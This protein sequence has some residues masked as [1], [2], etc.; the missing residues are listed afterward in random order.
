MCNTTPHSLISCITG[1]KHVNCFEV[2][3]A[4]MKYISKKNDIISSR[5][6][7]HYMIW[8][9]KKEKKI[10]L[11]GKG[12]LSTCLSLPLS[13]YPCENFVLVCPRIYQDGDL[14]TVNVST[15]SKVP[16]FKLTWFLAIN[17]ISLN[18]NFLAPK[19]LESSLITIVVSN[20]EL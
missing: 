16:V 1:I 10:T 12:M 2:E 14:G 11:C 18:I 4:E 6:E 13:F 5:G 17:S 7:V 19:S 3:L 9:E 15:F 20:W 8:I